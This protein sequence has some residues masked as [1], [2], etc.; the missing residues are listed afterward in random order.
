MIFLKFFMIF[1]YIFGCL[2]R[3]YM[4]SYSYGI[5]KLIL[6]LIVAIF[7]KKEKTW[8]DH[9]YNSYLLIFMIPYSIDFLRI[10]INSL[11]LSKKGI[12]GVDEW[13]DKKKYLI[14]SFLISLILFL[15]LLYMILINMKIG[16]KKNE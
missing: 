4:E 13:K 3:F 16:I 15:Y 14:L 8:N 10:H 12:F 7:F 6:V 9:F 5:L 1:P 2:D 11:S